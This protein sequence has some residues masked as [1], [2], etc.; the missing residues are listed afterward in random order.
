MSGE[1]GGAQYFTLKNNLCFPKKSQ[2]F[3]ISKKIIRKSMLFIEFSYND[4]LEKTEDKYSTFPNEIK[5]QNQCGG[6]SNKIQTDTAVIS[7]KMM[8]CMKIKI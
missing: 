1:S 7:E 5:N 2:S 8:F 6:Q 3:Y 4:R